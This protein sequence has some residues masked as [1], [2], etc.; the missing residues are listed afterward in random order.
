MLLLAEALVRLLQ[1][2]DEGRMRILPEAIM[3]HRIPIVLAQILNRT[4][5][6]QTSNGG[7]ISAESPEVTA[8]AVLTLVAISTLPW[9]ALLDSEINSAIEAGR[10]F[11]RQAQEN[12]TAPQYVWVEKV[13]YA[14][15]VLSEAYC[16]AAM[17]VPTST[18]SWSDRI[19][20]LV[21]I[22]EKRLV[23]FA[24]FF[25]TLETFRDEPLWKLKASMI[26][27]CLFL[28]QLKSARTDILP[29][30]QGAKNE[31][32]DYIPS[33]WITISNHKG[34][35]LESNLLWNMMVLTVC[36]FRVDEYME[37]TAAKLGQDK[38]DSVGSTIRTLCAAEESAVTRTR[39][40]PHEE[41]AKLMNDDANSSQVNG[42]G[43][44]SETGTVKAVLA[45]YVQ[46]MLNYPL[47]SDASPSDRSQLRLQLQRFLL[48]HLSQ[49][50]DNARFSSQ[51]SRSLGTT[52]AFLAPS[53]TF[54]NWAH[55]I[56]AESV[57][58][59]FSFAFLTCLLGVLY[60]RGNDCFSSVYQKYLAN[61]LCSH[62]SVMSRLYND[63]GSIVRDRAEANLNSVNFPEFHE[64][65]SKDSAD[66]E[67]REH[68]LKTELLRLA[69]YE[70]DCV[71]AAAERFDKDLRQTPGNAQRVADGLLL[72][73]GV[74]KVYAD[75]YVA[76]DLSNR[77]EIT[78]GM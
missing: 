3:R 39:K 51:R 11:L 44:S 22:P 78:N 52:E 6:T 14:N 41:S 15:T 30:Q 70:R 77:V 50:K 32:L 19:K 61:D 62:L 59:P 53:S 23:R 10:T 2:C 20:N 40:R 24:K 72:F 73:T 45:P 54:Y 13:T 31:Y 17:N 55:T 37:T 4:L 29:R 1:L 42:I 7:W 57:S 76:K 25:S 66:N 21:T 63:Y 75:I 68:G 47:V 18:Y 65:F 49:I 27:G 28:P 71:E 58:C 8:Y 35:F 26:E 46:A 48:A 64:P 5:L 60:N 74:A 9:T 67:D 34:L 33:T 16:L 38:W 43:E 69:Q 36:N 56:G 12:W